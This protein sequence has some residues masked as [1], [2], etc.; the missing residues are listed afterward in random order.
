MIRLQM[1][2]T[3]IR[4]IS[5]EAPKVFCLGGYVCRLGETLVQSVPGQ[6]PGVGVKVGD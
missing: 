1:T 4:T 5:G 6:I 3:I 2:L